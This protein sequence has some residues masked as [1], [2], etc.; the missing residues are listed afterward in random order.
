[1]NNFFTILGGMGS[2]ATES[3]VRLL[4]ARTPSN[5]DQDY[6]DY[7]VIN[8]ATIPDRSSYIMDH[9]QT[10]PLPAL[11]ADITQQSKLNPAFFVLT[12]NSAHY[13]YPQLQSATTIPI[14][15]MPKLAVEQIKE[16]APTAHRVGILG[17]PGSINNGI[18]DNLLIS[19]G[20]EPVKPTPEILAAT[21]ELIFTD[22]K[23]NGQVNAER[24]HHLLEQ[25]QT[26]LNCDATILGCTELSLAQ[27]KAANHPYQVIDAQSIL[28]DQTLKLGLAAQK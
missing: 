22:I 13:F 4:N 26:E 9:S 17:T 28:V 15:H 23:Q 16:I 8:H 2:L 12:C 25:M 1:M 20:Y 14:L 18:Y 27:E 10:N 7:I 6:L 11:L 24:F 19:N 5:R 21:E 3:F